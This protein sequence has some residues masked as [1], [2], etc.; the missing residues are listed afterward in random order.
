MCR[1]LE[2]TLL[3]ASLLPRGAVAAVALVVLLL[4]AVF[5][6]AA[7]SSKKDSTAGQ[8]DAGETSQSSFTDYVPTGYSI[9]GPL[10]IV[11]VTTATIGFFSG[12]TTKPRV[13]NLTGTKVTVKDEKNKTLPFSALTSGVRVYVCRSADKKTIIIFVV[14][15]TVE[16]KSDV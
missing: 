13:L 15:S 10:T 8:T 3:Q 12:R 6:V 11:S 5:D 16:G 1:K 9:E 2:P 7:A 4:V 14:P